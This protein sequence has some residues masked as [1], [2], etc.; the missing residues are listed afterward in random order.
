M[1]YVYIYAFVQ[2]IYNMYY[3]TYYYC[4]K[5]AC[6]MCTLMHTYVSVCA[7]LATTV[8]CILGMRVDE[9]FVRT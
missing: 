5:H 7:R 1:L 6:I 4:M 2:D 9:Y 3:I 8:F